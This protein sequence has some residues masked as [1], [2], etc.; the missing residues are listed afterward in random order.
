[1]KRHTGNKVVSRWSMI[2]TALLLI[3]LVTPIIYFQGC[4][5][6][7]A[8]EGTSAKAT[9]TQPLPANHPAQVEKLAQEKLK[10][11]R[12]SETVARFEGAQSQELE[13]AKKALEQAI[14][15]QGKGQKLGKGAA[16]Q[17]QGQIFNHGLFRVHIRPVSP[18]FPQLNE[19]QLENWTRLTPKHPAVRIEKEAGS[20]MSIP[21]PG[22]SNSSSSRS[23]PR[24]DLAKR[25]A[26]GPQGSMPALEEELWVIAKPNDKN[27]QAPE[28]DPG[29]GALMARLPD[30]REQIPLPLK[31][32]T[33]EAAVNGY[34]ASVEVIQKFNNPY[35][36]KIEAVYMFP[37]PQNSA[38]NEFIMVIGERRIRGIIR[39]R[40]EAK[41]IYVAAKRQGYTASLLTQERPNIFTQKVA[42]IEPGKNIDIHIKY[43]NTLN[44]RDGWYEF[45]FPMVVGPR[46]NPPGST[47]GIGAVARGRHG[48]SGQKN[49]VQYLKP[50][51]RS[52]HD[53]D[54]SVTLNTGV[55]IEDI[56]CVNHGF[57]KEG[58]EPGRCK[59][60]IAQNDRIPNKDFVLRYRVAGK[61]IKS[62]LITHKDKDGEKYFTLMLYPPANLKSLERQPVEL[63]FVL[64]CSGSMR[65]QP[66]NQAKAAIRKGLGRL[67]PQDTFQ[68]IRF[69]N[70]AS[71]LGPRPLEAT[72]E[73]IQ[74]GLAYLSGLNSTGGT[75][76][77]EGIKAA[78][79]FAHDEN[80]LRF[81]CFLT[82]G[83]IGND[84]QIIGE[85]HKRI[86]NSRIFS[87]G[88]GSSPNRYL[89]NR[90]AKLGRGA[91]GY[92]SLHDDGAEVM[93]QFFNSISHPA[94][95]DIKVD[96]GAMKVKDHY[97]ARIPDLFVGRP[98]ILTGRYEGD[99]PAE[100][101]VNG[102][103][104]AENTQVLIKAGAPAAGMANKAIASVW[105]RMKIADLA[106]RSTYT[107]NMELPSQIKEIALNYSLMSNF[108][109][110]VAVDSSRRTE[111]ARGTTVTQVLPV[112]EGVEYETTVRE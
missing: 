42:N 79:D 9:T 5:A 49:E 62:N 105:A 91:V 52:G 109:A 95:T 90:M 39:E 56:A 92:L 112:P 10:G 100:L 12:T 50:T 89:M 111:G 16:E 53:I 59:I 55:A 23:T 108:T 72:Q 37:L 57:K 96:W 19:Q 93:D 41:K 30:T 83:Y 107:P 80:R 102:R 27:A 66:I 87:F 11:A 43:F 4:K 65:G 88:V 86:S 7:S 94:M 67:N 98:V 20:L 35:D 73:N 6:S 70:N 3:L 45:V 22:R 101:R 85:V 68:I 26:A 58:D 51:E 48:A 44:Y 2:I 84:A 74:K 31:H 13:K 106:D 64:D 40:E 8:D 97:P 75:K 47:N 14:S 63:I 82:D 54:L 77:I 81:V 15:K 34:I 69:S 28:D 21:F 1:M 71:Q 38:V 99:L 78:L 32:T 36:S 29:C 104:G 46:F 24:V 61:R 76:V 60:A 18:G 33:V 110:F 103:S 17:A 25:L